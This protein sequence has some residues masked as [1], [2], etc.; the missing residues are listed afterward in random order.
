MAARDSFNVIR[1]LAVGDRKLGYHSLEAAAAAGLGGLARLPY[2]L[3]VLLENALRHE[4]GH[5]VTADDIAALA[6]W[7]QHR[8]AAGEIAFHPVRILM[9]DSSGIPLLADL[10]A[11]RD[12]MR[13][14][15]G[16]PD[17][18]N[19]VIPAQLIVDH[20]LNVDLAGDPAAAAR[21]REMEYVR[22][23]ERYSFLKWAQ[24]S[25]RNLTVVPPGVGI[26][27]QI[28]VEF[29]ARVV[30]TA[31]ANGRQMAFPDSLLGMDS[32][33]PM[34]NSLGVFG[35]GV[36]GIEAAAALL[37]QPVSVPIPEVVGCRL[38]GR[39][40]R[41]LTATDIV[42]A[43]TEGLRARGV[44]QKF[45]E[46]WGD[47]VAA[48]TLTDRATIANMAPEYGATMGFFPV[49]RQT[50]DYLALSGREAG[51]IA[52][53]EAYARAQGLWRDAATPEPAFTKKESA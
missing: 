38:R 26:C 8:R 24:R 33:T 50:L 34:V 9:P 44:V 22:N 52:L 16:D 19:P 43:L 29:L 12:A 32:H 5:V 35:W 39:P 4:D 49:D 3:K 51:Q 45:V 6:A 46:F 48:L 36:G 25:F 2:S 41:G 30:W 40:R 31:P 37:G 7:P 21:N 13:Q 1:T 15:G 28:N 11:M 27:H 20:S 14:L 18:V 42:L 23:R 10:A 53:V 47:G 17:R